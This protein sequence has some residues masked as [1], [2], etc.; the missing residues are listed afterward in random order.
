[1][2]D[3]IIQTVVRVTTEGESEQIGNDLKAHI[4][5]G[6][7]QSGTVVHRYTVENVE[8][9]ELP[10]REESTNDSQNGS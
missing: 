4:Q 6:G 3:F 8:V 10:G 2:N 1:M 9:T 5:S 7:Y